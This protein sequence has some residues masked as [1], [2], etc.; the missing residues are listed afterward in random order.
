MRAPRDSHTIDELTTAPASTVLNGYTFT[1]AASDAVLADEALVAEH[2]ALLEAGA[3][4]DVAR[5]PDDRAP[6]PRTLA[7]VGVVVDHRRARGRRRRGRGRSSRAPC[8]HRAGRRPRPDSLSPM[9]A[10]PTTSAVGVDLGALAEPHRLGDLEAGDVDAR[11][12]RR[13]RPCGR[14]GRPRA[15]RRPPSSPTA[16]APTSGLPVGEQPR[17]HVAREVDRLVPVDVLEDLRA[18]A[19]RCRC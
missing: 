10:G 19:R 3:A 5:A 9:T 13:G 17:E 15:C 2:D 11:P 18:R 7:E 12:G 14:G 6:Q 4:A 8:T 1:P 16:I